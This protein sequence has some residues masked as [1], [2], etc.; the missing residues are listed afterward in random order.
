MKVVMAIGLNMMKKAIQFIMK[1]VK[2]FGEKNEYN[3]KGNLIYFEDS[4]GF[5]SKREYDEKGQCDLL[6]E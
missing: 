1:I 4:N 2:T 3:E 6:R 5:W